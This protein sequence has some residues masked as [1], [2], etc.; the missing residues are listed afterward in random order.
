MNDE[1]GLKIPPH[2]IESEQSILGGLMLNSDAWDDVADIVSES[3]FYR[4]EHKLIWRHISRMVE[5]GDTV[6]VLTVAESLSRTGKLEVIGG[7]PYL[8]TLASDTPSVANIKRYAKIV[9]DKS[10]ERRIMVAAYEISDIAAGNESADQ[11]LEKISNLLTTLEGDD[12]TPIAS[13]SE[14]AANAIETL[15]RRFASSGEI[16]GFKTGFDEFDRM[17]GGLQPSDLIIIA[18]RPSMGKSAFAVNIAENVAQ[19]GLPALVFSLEMSKEQ[20]AFRTIAS[21]GSVNMSRMR[22]GRLDDEDWPRLTNAMGKIQDAQLFIDDNAM[23]TATQMHARA[24]S[25]KRKH[26]LA[27]IVIDYLQLMTEGGENRNTE[28]STITRKLKLMAK[29]L[30]VPVICLS[31]LSRKLEER[32]DKRPMM[33]DLRDSGAIEQDADVVVMMYRDEYYNPDTMNKGIAEAIICKQRM[34]PTGTVLLTFQGEYSKFSD[35]TGNYHRQERKMQRGFADG[36]SKAS[37]S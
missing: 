27:L 15:E 11:K 3:D 23:T 26:G 14:A 9:A 10:A 33:S 37:G 1:S 7:L 25:M 2:N 5:A 6:D 21:T 28:L 4:N 18:G 36:K 29:D 8:G 13:V 20:L 31:Q 16:H 24:R 34:G 19:S 30:N 32:G 17:L 12:K 22:S 35:F